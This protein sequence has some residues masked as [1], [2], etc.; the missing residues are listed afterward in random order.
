MSYGAPQQQQ[1]PVPPPAYE[2]DAHQPLF[3][4]HEAGDDMYKE[5][6][7]NSPMEIRMRMLLLSFSHIQK[8]HFTSYRICTQGVLHSDCTS[9]QHCCALC[10]VHV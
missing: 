7:A 4:D 10:G 8:A 6:I 3:G 5:T 1:Y 9:A 2:E